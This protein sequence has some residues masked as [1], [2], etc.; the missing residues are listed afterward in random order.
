MNVGEISILLLTNVYFNKKNGAKFAQSLSL[1]AQIYAS[2][3]SYYGIIAT[4]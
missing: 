4:A 3:S 2:S 1:H